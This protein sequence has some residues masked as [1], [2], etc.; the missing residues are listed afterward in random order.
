MLKRLNL[1]VL[2]FQLF[3]ISAFPP[4]FSLSTFQLLLHFVS[5]FTPQNS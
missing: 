3:R 2:K 1:H 4:L 5:G